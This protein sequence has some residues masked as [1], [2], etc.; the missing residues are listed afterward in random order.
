M[1][2]QEEENLK[3]E[4]TGKHKK[5]ID[6]YKQ[7]NEILEYCF[8]EK[9][10]SDFS[11]SII[12][13]PFRAIKNWMFS[14]VRRTSKPGI[15]FVLLIGTLAYESIH[16]YEIPEAIKPQIIQELTNV[17]NWTQQ[18]AK[19]INTDFIYRF[20]KIESPLPHIPEAEFKPEPQFI[21]AQVSGFSNYVSGQFHQW[22]LL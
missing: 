5:E 10:P 14:I 2:K 18:A 19:N 9:W 11:D 15:I 16:I 12:L 3:L 6:Q 4:V 7:D 21:Y 22:K 13:I 20:I 8:F 1:T 17:G